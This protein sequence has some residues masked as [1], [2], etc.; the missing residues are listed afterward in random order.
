[1]AHLIFVELLEYIASQAQPGGVGKVHLHHFFPDRDRQ[2]EVGFAVPR[3]LRH[4]KSILRTLIEDCAAEHHAKGNLAGIE[5]VKIL[6]GGNIE[7]ESA[8]QLEID[9]D[10]AVKPGTETLVSSRE[11]AVRFGSIARLAE[12]I[13]QLLPFFGDIAAAGSI[14]TWHRSMR[15]WIASVS[16]RLVT[17]SFR[18]I[19]GAAALATASAPR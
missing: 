6:C 4:L 3:H 11:E 15:L 19:S 7:V 12:E 10:V 9:E 8:R 17:R 18:A 5:R 14:C 1:M 13:E 2:A 16:G